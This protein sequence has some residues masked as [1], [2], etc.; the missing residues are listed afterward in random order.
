MPSDG[1]GK[2]PKGRGDPPGGVISPLTGDQCP[3]CSSRVICDFCWS[4]FSRVE[5]EGDEED[6]EL[7]E[8][9]KQWLP[10]LARWRERQKASS[11]QS[12]PSSSSGTASKRLPS[13]RR[14]LGR[15]NHPDHNSPPHGGVKWTSGDPKPSKLREPESRLSHQLEF[16]DY[17]D[18]APWTAA[19]TGDLPSNST[20]TLSNPH[21]REG[22]SAGGTSRNVTTTCGPPPPPS[23]TIHS[24]SKAGGKQHKSSKGTTTPSGGPVIVTGTDGKQYYLGDDNQYHP[25]DDEN[26][27]DDSGG[28]SNSFPAGYGGG[29]NPQ[30]RMPYG[31]R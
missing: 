11:S 15:L 27:Y 29:S 23:P 5:A 12:G 24:R 1:K 7:L 2:K 13:T 9:R 6:E 18:R 10:D 19:Y 28:G 25:W 14:S 3:G 20:Y 17:A 16:S 30:G 4:W 31:Q 22:S 8:S 21:N 26:P